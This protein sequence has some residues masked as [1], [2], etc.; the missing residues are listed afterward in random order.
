MTEQRADLDE[1]GPTHTSEG[2]ASATLNYG[3]GR[4]SFQYRPDTFSVL[5]HRGSSTRALGEAELHAALDSP[6]GTP[7]PEEG[8]RATDDVLIVVPD[9]TR[10]AGADRVV[11][12]LRKRLNGAGVPDSR[13]SILIGGGSHRLP[14]PAEVV[15]ILGPETPR[16]LAVHTHDS[17]DPDASVYLGETS[18]GTPVELNRRVVEADRLILVGAVGFHYVAG[19][20]G[21]RKGLLP[22]CASERS[23]RAHHLLAFDPDT[24]SQ[25]AGVATGRLD[26]N[27][28]HENLEEAARMIEP[29]FLFN[30]VVNDAN[31]IVAAYAGDLGR[32]HRRACEEYA[33]AH[34]ATVDARR[35]LVIA[36]CGGSPRDINLIQS[37][38]A[39][40]HASGALEEG[41]V[42]VVLAECPQGLGRDDFLDWFVPGGARATARR[43]VENYHVNGQ[44]A[45]GLRWK[46]ERFRI[47]LVSSLD[48]GVV[49]GMGLEPHASLASALGAAGRDRGY[50]LPNAAATLPSLGPAGSVAGAALSL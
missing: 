13:I 41:G 16:A 1:E 49:R 28:V 40:E 46:S 19:F 6:F 25:R 50:I 37:H 44:T 21:G 29:P 45:W 24:L 11:P 48:P 33:A 17:R 38:K 27:P 12:V 42:M 3:R 30:T 34:S 32:A 18:R 14:T 10:A 47:L 39:I 20:S 22:G 31:D 23:V 8:L 35:P 2:G 5:S 15:S 36:S 4:V 7:P 26:G 9:A 43:L